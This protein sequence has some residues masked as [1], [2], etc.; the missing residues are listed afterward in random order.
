[1]LYLPYIYSIIRS[2]T[3]SLSQNYLA[4][5]FCVLAF[6]Q[7]HYY[8][9]IHSI[10]RTSELQLCTMHCSEHSKLQRATSS[11]QLELSKEVW[12]QIVR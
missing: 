10:T 4:L 2:I 5:L 8:S 7:R 11:E 12:G 6:L 1:M 9:M 3:S